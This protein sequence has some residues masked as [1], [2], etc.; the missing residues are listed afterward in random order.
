MLA[1]SSHGEE[2]EVGLGQEVILVCVVEASPA[3]ESHSECALGHPPGHRSL[4]F[5]S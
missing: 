1:E 4:T 3:V 2:G 5:A